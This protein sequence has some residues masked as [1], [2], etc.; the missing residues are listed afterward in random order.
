VLTAPC[1]RW[2][3]ML[4]FS[5]LIGGSAASAQPAADRLELPDRVYLASRI[6][7]AVQVYFAH[8]DS[9]PFADIESAYRRYVEQLVHASG[10]REF[11]LLTLR[12]V[13]ALKNGHTHFRDQWL[14]ATYG[15]PLPFWLALVEGKW[16]VARTADQRLR[17][18]DIV[19][20]IDGVS[21]DRFVQRQAAS[22]GASNE[23]IARSWVFYSPALFSERF[24]LTLEDGREVPI[25][26]GA[27]VQH[28]G[29][30]RPLEPFQAPSS[31]GRWIIEGGVAYIKIP[32]FGD[33]GF[34]RT[35]LELVKRFRAA[36]CLIV[37]VRGNGGGSTPWQLIRALMNRPWRTWREKSPQRIALYEAQGGP[38]SALDL[39]SSRVSAEE[40]AFG[41]QVIL[42]VDRYAGSAAEDFVMPFKDTGRGILVGETTQGSSGQPYRLDLGN[43]MSLM[44]GAARYWFPDGAP[45][46]GVGITPDVPVQPR[47]A[48]VRNDVDS[49]L[50]KAVELAHAL[51]K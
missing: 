13:A 2:V 45:F 43:G 42:L 28:L 35:A 31:E 17:K 23:R 49:V 34:E 39:P 48:D 18:G 16:V 5:V 4:S 27:T 51:R 6:Y 47:I 19:R 21:M 38:S 26:R 22:I 1:C 30:R 11:D 3:L 36:R 40:S 10:R 29:A 7:T 25:E 41:G 14:D 46:E 44:V 15:Q 24:T 32:S 9:V 50:R 33:P 20:T 8:S 37:D 12:F